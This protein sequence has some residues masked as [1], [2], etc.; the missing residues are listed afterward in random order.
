MT[1]PSPSPTVADHPAFSIRRARGVDYATWYIR[2]KAKQLSGQYGFADDAADDLRQELTLHLLEQWPAFDPAVAKA[3]TFVQNVIDFKVCELIRDQ[4]REK[5]DYRRE[6]PLS[7]SADYGQL[8]GVRGQPETSELNLIELREDC[9]QIL[10]TLPADLR[11]IAQLLKEMSP[12]AAARL[13]RRPESTFWDRLAELREHFIAAGF[14]APAHN[15]A[16]NNEELA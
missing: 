6:Q 8:D 13:L 3:T 9:A 14:E 4:Q 15:T 2:R 10:S 7:G 12:T 5:R 11:T 1:A 16:I